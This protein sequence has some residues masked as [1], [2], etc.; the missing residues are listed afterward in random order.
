MPKAAPA[1]RASGAEGSAAAG[2]K[3][4]SAA[5]LAGCAA[6]STAPAAC[7]PTISQQREHDEEQE[8]QPELRVKRRRKLKGFGPDF[9]VHRVPSKHSGGARGKNHALCQGV[10]AVVPCRTKMEF[11]WTHCSA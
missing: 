11:Q 7:S 4:D 9:V 5:E 3:A 10:S 6:G 1:K 8:Q 2:S